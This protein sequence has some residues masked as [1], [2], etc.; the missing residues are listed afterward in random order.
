M[1][2]PWKVIVVFVGVFIA[3]AV[4]GG[5]FA[6]R[7]QSSWFHRPQRSSLIFTAPD[8]VQKLTERLELSPEQ[9]QKI[10]PIVKR[11]QDEVQRLRRDH[12]RN[13]TTA[14][15]LMHSEISEVLTPAQRVKLEELRTR[16]RE[17]SR[18]QRDRFLG[19]DRPEKKP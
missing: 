3:G 14:L 11:A 2:R 16:L 4:F 15:D 9:T 10:E 19:N 17:R 6:L 8:I 5:L 1:N 13:M 12:V 18:Q 7:F